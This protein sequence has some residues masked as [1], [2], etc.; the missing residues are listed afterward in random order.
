MVD[1]KKMAT[2]IDNADPYPKYSYNSGLCYS[3]GEPC[4]G[5]D[6]DWLYDKAENGIT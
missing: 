3:D 4:Y 6:L 5:E 2:E 1:F